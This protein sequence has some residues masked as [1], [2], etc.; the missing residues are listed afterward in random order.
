MFAGMQYDST[1]GLYYDHAR[2]YDAAIGRFVSQDPKGFAAGD[3]NLYRYVSNDPTESVD[4]SGEDRAGMWGGVAGGI[5]G[6]LLVGG[7]IGGWP[8]A[9]IGAIIGGIWGGYDG[10]QQSG[11][12]AGLNVGMRDGAI[13]GLIGGLISKLGVWIIG[14]INPP[15]PTP[16]S[17]WYVQSPVN[18][19][20]PT[21]GQG[22]NLA[23][24]CRPFRFPVQAHDRPSPTV[25]RTKILSMRFSAGRLGTF[26]ARGWVR[27]AALSICAA[28]A[29]LRGPPDLHGPAAVG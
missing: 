14:K 22:S 26:P 18:P 28:D 5:G 2:Y 29:D 24:Y 3:T 19:L 4:P 9:I 15:P 27:R 17:P 13:S 21:G 11:G 12:W 8:G 20:L 7:L 23:R 6:G 1:T 25:L 10:S 16:T